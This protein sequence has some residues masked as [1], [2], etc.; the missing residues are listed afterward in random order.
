MSDTTP[1]PKP[2]KAKPTRKSAAAPQT[3]AGDA[4]TAASSADLGAAPPVP[5]PP[6]PPAPASARHV[7]PRVLRIALA[8]SVGLN[9]AVLGV[10]AGSLW[11]DGNGGG[12]GQMVRDLGFGP[13]AEALASDDRRA[14]RDWL[15][16]RAPELRSANLQ[17]YA[18]LAAVQDALR[19]QPFD[20]AALR[21]AFEAMRGRMEGQL[22]LGHQALTEVILAMPDAERLALADR[23]ER[24]MRRGHDEAEGHDAPSGQN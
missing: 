5:P 14:L 12:R 6:S 9:L 17:R 7:S 15:K 23:L 20:P 22:A 16:A 18:D 3:A 11:H 4:Q 1:T 13:F 24:G 2:A 8:V 10:V 21:A 19:A